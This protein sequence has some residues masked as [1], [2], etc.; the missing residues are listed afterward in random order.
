M[1]LVLASSN[2]GKL[3]EIGALLAPLSIDLVSQS[4]LGITDAEEPHDTFLEKLPAATA[5]TARR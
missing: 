5:L 3:R 4:S 2:P 1:K